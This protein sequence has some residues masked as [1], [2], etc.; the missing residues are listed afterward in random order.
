MGRIE[1]AFYKEFYVKKLLCC[2]AD[3][4]LASS[5][6]NLYDM[7]LLL[8]IQPKHVTLFSQKVLFFV[9]K[10]LLYISAVKPNI[11]TIFSSLL[12]I[13]LHVSD[14]L[15]FYHQESKTVHTA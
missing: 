1:L 4:L 15:S 14:G 10:Y 7:Y 13:T 3:Y 8:C 2:Y 9:I 6:Y 5:Q 12:N 11:C